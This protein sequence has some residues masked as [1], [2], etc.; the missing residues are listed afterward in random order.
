M[1]EKV[2]APREASSGASLPR[3]V[4]AW[5]AELVFTGFSLCP[6]FCRTARS[7]TPRAAVLVQSDPGDGEKQGADIHTHRCPHTAQAHEL[8][9]R[10]E[11][12]KSHGGKV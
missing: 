12:A 3:Q 4:S 5:G 9:P 2:Q 8:H 10:K 11:P 7:C 6:W 1:H